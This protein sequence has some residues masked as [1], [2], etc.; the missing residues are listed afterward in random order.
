MLYKARAVQENG[1]PTEI[2]DPAT[3]FQRIYQQN[4]I[5]SAAM[6]EQGVSNFGDTTNL[7]RTMLKLVTGQPCTPALCSQGKTGVAHACSVAEMDKFQ[8]WN[9]MSI[10]DLRRA[11][12]QGGDAG[13]QH[14]RRPWAQGW[15]ELLGEQ[16]RRL[17]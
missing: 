5:M 3:L 10:Y 17:D 11:P 14:Y 12:H 1:Q 4:I 6:L 2:S 15:P 8:L 9:G 7:R 16:D 13:R